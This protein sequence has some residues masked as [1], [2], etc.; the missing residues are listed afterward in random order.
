MPEMKEYKVSEILDYM[1]GNQNLTNQVI[2]SERNNLNGIDDIEVLSSSVDK[3]F[4]MGYVS[5]NLHL[6][7]KP[8]KTFEDKEGILVS[9]NGNAGILTY[10]PKGRYTM[11][12]HAYILFIK[13]E[14]NNF[15][16][17]FYL[18]LQ[19]QDESLKFL[20]TRDGNKNWN[21][22]K[23]MN[24]ARVYIPTSSDGKFDL[25]S[26]KD[27][28][29]IYKK[30]EDKKDSLL[31]KCRKLENL[32]IQLDKESNI[33]YKDVPLNTIIEH[34][35]GKASYTK[36]WCKNNKGE[37]PIY[38]ANNT[39]PFSFINHFDFN[40]E[41]LTYSKNGCAGYISIIKGKFSINGDRCVIKINTNYKNDIDIL[42]LKYYLEPIFRFNKK[43][44]IG[45]L[46]K[47]EFTKL[48]SNMIKKLNIQVP[49]PITSDGTFDLEKQKEIANKYRQID[50]IKKGLLEKIQKIVSIKIKPSS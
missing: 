21:I 10:L 48:N 38:S 7:N 3:S 6:N 34:Y 33:E 23:F 14:F 29:N 37:F 36:Q 44:R 17:T 15:I 25:K 4:S 13:P 24:N 28:A 16:D 9:R 32:T 45:D 30:I 19:L 39:K 47:N 46:G 20:S 26:Q 41:Y 49:I 8:L 12:D 35:N 31:D 27:L 40:G 22:T 43:G 42:Y 2:H 11:N 18:S 50:E 5:K 1:S